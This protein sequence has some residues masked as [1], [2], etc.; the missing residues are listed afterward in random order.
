MPT[1]PTF[2]PVLTMTRAEMLALGLPDEWDC[3]DESKKATIISDQITG[4]RRWSNVHELIFR[5]PGMPDN[6]AYR[7]HYSTGKTEMQDESP[8]EYESATCTL[9]QQVEKV[10]KVWE[11]MKTTE[12]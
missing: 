4:E 11:P 9:M 5:L 2:A 1:D 10:I 7:T 3:E 8:W 6:L 12:S